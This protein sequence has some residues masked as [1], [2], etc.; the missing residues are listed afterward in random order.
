MALERASRQAFLGV[1][2]LAFVASAVTT[3][4]W[5]T[6]MSAMGEMSMPGGW[7]MSMAWVRMPG[8]AW[9]GAAAS[10]LCMW[11]VMM[12]AMMLPSIVPVL[13]RYREAVGRAGA[14]HPGWLTALAGTGYFFVWAVF[15]AAVFPLGAALSTIA[16]Q[17]PAIARAAPISIG[18]VVLVAG[19]LQLTTWSARRLEGCWEP[20]RSPRDLLPDA[21]TAWRYGVRLGL[22]CGQACAGLMTIL[23]VVGVMDLRVMAIVTAAITVERLAPAPIRVAR[24]IG[25]VTVGAGLLMTARAVVGALG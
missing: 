8:Q 17:Q 22:E 10:F 18:A 6:S 12:A 7:T 19:A 3:I 16:M 2:A 5:S 23:L 24:V 1:T 20:R 13:W 9:P 15:G 21:G 4:E 11:I 25:A 14:T